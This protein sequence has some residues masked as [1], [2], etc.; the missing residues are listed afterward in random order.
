[1][2][3]QRVTQMCVPGAGSSLAPDALYADYPS[4]TPRKLRLVRSGESDVAEARDQA[5]VEDF[6]GVGL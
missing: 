2:P 4:G 5:D 6:H 3:L 1:M